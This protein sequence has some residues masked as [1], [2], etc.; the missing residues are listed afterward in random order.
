MAGAA[1]VGDR[2]TTGVRDG[3]HVANHVDVSHRTYGDRRIHAAL[4]RQGEQVSPELAR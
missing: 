1:D 4:V 3:A 2:A